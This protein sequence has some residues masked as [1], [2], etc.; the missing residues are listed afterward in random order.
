[1]F[2]RSP[3]NPPAQS[4]DFE[5]AK[6]RAQ[7]ISRAEAF[8]WLDNALTA[9]WKHTEQLHKDG[10]YPLHMDAINPALESI[11]GVLAGLEEKWAG[12]SQDISRGH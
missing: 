11:R 6:R 9:V 10:D 7:V 5:T 8:M 3:K 12:A 2:G 1:M 4:K